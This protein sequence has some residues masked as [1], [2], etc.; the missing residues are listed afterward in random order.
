MVENKSDQSKDIATSGK[1]A[2]K[3]AAPSLWEGWTEEEKSYAAGM[4]YDKRIKEEEEKKE[5]EEKDKEQKGKG[6]G[7]RGSEGKGGEEKWEGWRWREL[8]SEGHRQDKERYLGKG[9]GGKKE[10]HHLESGEKKK[11]DDKGGEEEEKV[12]VYKIEDSEEEE[13]GDG[14]MEEEGW[15]KS[16]IPRWRALEGRM[17]Y[18]EAQCSAGKT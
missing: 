6:S 14:K 4:I 3:K 1:V 7:E 5:K 15:K 12:D 9:K 18:V 10:G 2:P 13:E 16:M 11:D 8:G 17:K